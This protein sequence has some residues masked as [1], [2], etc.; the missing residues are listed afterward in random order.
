[1]DSGITNKSDMNR[2]Y[3]FMLLPGASQTMFISCLPILYDTVNTILMDSYDFKRLQAQAATLPEDRQTQIRLSTLESL[4]Q[5]GNIETID[6]A[7]FYSESDKRRNIGQMWEILRDLPDDS[8]EAAALDINQGHLNI[9]RGDFQERF[10]S[11]IGN[12]DIHKQRRQ[13][14]EKQQRKFKRSVGEPLEFCENVFAQYLAALEVRRGINKHTNTYVSAIITHGGEHGLSRI[15]R[16]SEKNLDSNAIELRNGTIDKFG[17]PYP[18]HPAARH[19]LIDEI[20]TVTKEFTGIDDQDFCLLGAQF[21]VPI[22]DRDITARGHIELYDTKGVAREAQEAVEYLKAK[23]DAQTPESLDY[24]AE[25]I[26]EEG[27]NAPGPVK[28]RLERM[29]DLAHYTD[30]LRELA[31]NEKFSHGALLVAATVISD[32]A[33]RF[34]EDDLWRRAHQLSVRSKNSDIS[35]DEISFFRNREQIRR[36]DGKDTDWYHSPNSARS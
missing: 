36:G 33:R 27:P 7:Q 35:N 26:A 25:F 29:A 28:K 34:E 24:E 31:D 10:R 32:P 6:Y 21:S 12:L 13:K 23:R 14:L 16:D 20:E 17:H 5:R 18:G 4:K 30:E 15:L 2:N 9:R 8:I 3:T 1:M 19:G 11:A 22:L